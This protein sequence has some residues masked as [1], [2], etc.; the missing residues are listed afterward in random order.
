[1]DS[2]VLQLTLDGLLKDAVTVPLPSA[3]AEQ[4]CRAATQEFLESLTADEQRYLQGPIVYH[5]GGWDAGE[6]I[7]KLIPQARLELILAGE[8]EMATLE[9]TLAYLASASLCF[10]L[11][12]EDAEIMLWLTQDVLGKHKLVHGD[13]P[14]WEMLGRTEPFALTPYIEHEVLN[15][16]RRKIRRAVV[17]HSTVRPVRK[18]KG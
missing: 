9:E 3:T 7:P 6:I 18:P 11:Q 12:R 15:S 13:Q 2:T 16:L 5:P 17:R 10:P 1:M 8:K 4:A 14:I